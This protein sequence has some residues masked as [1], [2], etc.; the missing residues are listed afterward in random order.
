MGMFGTIGSML[1]LWSENPYDQAAKQA[2]KASKAMAQGYSEATP[3][4]QAGYRQAGQALQTGLSQVQQILD[5]SYQQAQLDAIK[6]YDVASVDFNNATSIL[7]AVGDIIKQQSDYAQAAMD[8]SNQMAVQLADALAAEEMQQSMR[9]INQAVRQQERL[10][11]M[12]ASGARSERQDEGLYRAVSEASRHAGT[13]GKMRAME[14]LLTGVALKG[15][16]AQSLQS[17]AG[18]YQKAGAIQEA[19]GQQAWAHQM[20]KGQTAADIAN[21]AA[22]V[23]AQMLQGIQNAGAMG[24]LGRAGANASYHGNMMQIAPAQSNYNTQRLGNIGRMFY[25]ILPMLMGG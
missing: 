13:T 6:Y 14:Q 1:G 4:V 3:M 10:R 22:N 15:Q 20:E 8:P 12:G 19:R 11:R 24:A 2:K 25:E 7:S 5:Q 21:Q 17:L 23:R 18:E 16:Q 9:G